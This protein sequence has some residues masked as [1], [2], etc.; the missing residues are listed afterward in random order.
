MKDHPDRNKDKPITNQRILEQKATTQRR[1]KMKKMRMFSLSLLIGVTIIVSFASNAM[2]ANLTLACTTIS[3]QATLSYSVGGG[4]SVD[5]DSDGDT[6]TGGQQTTDF[7]VDT[8]VDLTVAIISPSVTATG[9]DNVL[10][11]TVTNLGNDEQDYQLILYNADTNATYNS[12]TLFT[13]TFDMEDIKVY[14]DT[15]PDGVFHGD[16]TELTFTGSGDSLG[17]VAGIA[18]YDSAT[19]SYFEVFVVANVPLSTASGAIAAYGLKA[20]T[21]QVAGEPGISGNGSETGKSATTTTRNSCSGDVILGDGNADTTTPNTIGALTDGDENGDHYAIG[22]Y[23]VSTANISVT[24]DVT[25]IWDPVNLGAGTQYY[26]PGA[27]VQYNIAIINSGSA[28][29]TLSTIMD[30]LVGELTI[31]PGLFDGTAG[32][33]DPA[34]GPYTNASGDGFVVELS[35]DD[36][37]ETFPLYFSTSN[38]DDG[39][40]HNSQVITATFSKIMVDESGTSGLGAGELTAGQTVKIKFNAIVK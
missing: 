12:G 31:D 23:V 15:V 19:A 24:K 18:G 13:D 21:H 1:M 8:L 26:I 4:S 20:I 40:D 30:T 3:N 39:L 14:Y 36:R 35:P 6:G 22:H 37:D 33:T 34:N 5:L 2:A 10:R 16:E 11:F 7:R 27:Y 38:N 29:A 32:T 28:S 17:E 9:I 25:V